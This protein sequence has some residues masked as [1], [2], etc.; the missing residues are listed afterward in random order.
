MRPAALSVMKSERAISKLARAATPPCSSKSVSRSSFTHTS[1]LFTAFEPFLIPII[2]TS[3]SPKLGLPIIVILL[4]GFDGSSVEYSVRL[5]TEEWLR[6]FSS[7]RAFLRFVRSSNGN[8][9]LFSSGQTAL[10]SAVVLFE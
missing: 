4:L 9:I 1:A 3:T 7:L 5:V 6:F 8:S 2:N 10:R